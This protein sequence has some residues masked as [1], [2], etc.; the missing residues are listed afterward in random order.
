MIKISVTKKP[1][2]RGGIPSWNET[3]LAGKSPNK[4]EISSSGFHHQTKWHC[5]VWWH[6]RVIGRHNSSRFLVWTWETH[7]NPMACHPLPHKKPCPNFG[8]PMPEIRASICWFSGWFRAGFPWGLVL[9]SGHS[10]WF[11]QLKTSIYRGL[12]E[13]NFRAWW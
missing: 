2:M 11:S 6:R 13:G 1:S 4:I 8:A 7:Q 10:G 9:S 12:P 5:Y 3:W